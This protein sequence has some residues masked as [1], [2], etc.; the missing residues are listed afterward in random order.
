MLPYLSRNKNWQQQ[1]KYN[2][3]QWWC[4]VSC[5]FVVG[6]LECKGYIIIQDF[7]TSLFLKILCTS[8]SSMP[9]ILPDAQGNLLSAGNHEMVQVL[10]VFR[11][12]IGNTLP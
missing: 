7:Y 6:Q 3:L 5:V 10:L 4:Y 9:K 12:Y 1:L 11:Y 2:G 8:S